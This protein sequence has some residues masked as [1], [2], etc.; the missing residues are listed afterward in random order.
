MLISMRPASCRHLISTLIRHLRG[1]HSP[2]AR[3]LVKGDVVRDLV[4][5]LQRS[6]RIP[7]RMD[8]PGVQVYPL[9]GTRCSLT[10]L[11]Y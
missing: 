5:L 4:A 9:D 8:H 2:K 11:L 6:P 3:L 7:R 10:Q 1:W